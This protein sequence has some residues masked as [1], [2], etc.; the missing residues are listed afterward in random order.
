MNT[1]YDAS[2]DAF[3]VI[4]ALGI[5]AASYGLPMQNLVLTGPES[6][7]TREARD[8]AIYLALTTLDLPQARVAHLFNVSKRRVQIAMK[9]I[10][11]PKF[12]PEAHRLGNVLQWVVNMAE[13]TFS[14]IGQGQNAYQLKEG[15]T[16][17][18]AAMKTY[19]IPVSQ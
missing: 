1:D 12:N 11:Q 14:P 7:R 10:G 15:D 2:I 4:A 13:F 8:M 18:F 3:R 17:T 19:A 5:T 16:S 9:H 6:L